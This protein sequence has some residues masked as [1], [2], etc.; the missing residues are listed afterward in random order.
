M[1]RVMP[2]EVEA[3]V[4]EMLFEL[5]EHVGMDGLIVIG[6]SKSLNMIMS[7]KRGGYPL[8]DMTVDLLRVTASHLGATTA[9]AASSR[10]E[11]D[12]VINVMM[13]AFREEIEDEWEIKNEI[14]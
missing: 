5:C 1:S 12:R 4:E 8:A 14:H 7:C 11:F 9:Y 3:V 2:E 10:E 13:D 6:D